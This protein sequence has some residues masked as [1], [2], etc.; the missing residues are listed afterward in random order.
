MHLV[1]DIFQGI[2][3]AAAVGIRPFLPA[4]AVGALA[5]GDVEIDFKGTDYHF[6]QSAPFLLVMV[7]GAIVLAVL[8]RRLAQER[9][10][11][12]P[13]VLVIGAVAVAIGALLC[14]G[15]FSRG[16]HAAWP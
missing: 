9:L 13:G 12:A 4:L 1:F 14:S 2:G 8:E 11:R 3:I 16:H 5:A 15:A 10:E 7:V 6:L